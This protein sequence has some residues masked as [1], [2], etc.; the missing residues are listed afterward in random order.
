MNERKDPHH[1]RE[2]G[3]EPPEKREPEYNP[4]EHRREIH[5]PESREHERP[6]RPRRR[7]AGREHQVHQEIVARR[8]EGGAPPT[9]DAY[10]EALKQW[11]QLP[12][13]IVRPPSDVGAEKEASETGQ[14]NPAAPDQDIPGEGEKGGRK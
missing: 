3:G 14:S 8:I 10:A 2:H 11:Q 9:P 7:R 5:E 6:E 12:G 1:N 4:E 13:S